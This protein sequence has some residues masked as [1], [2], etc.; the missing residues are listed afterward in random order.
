[1]TT[2]NNK[3]VKSIVAVSLVVLYCLLLAPVL[4]IGRYDYHCADDFGFSAS[5][6][7]A[8]E[9]THSIMDVIHVAG[10]SVV[11]RWHTWQGTF[12]TMFIMAIEPGIFGDTFYHLV[13]WIMIGLMTISVLYTFYVILVKLIGCQKS[14]WISLSMLYLIYA[15][16]CIVDPL[17][18]FFWY[19]G[20]VHYMI[21]HCLALLLVGFLVEVS[22]GKKKILLLIISSV[23]AFLLGGSNY[24]TALGTSIGFGYAIA[25]CFLTKK[26]EKLWIYI[27]PAITFIPAF[28]INVIAPGNSVRQ[29]TFSEHIGPIKAIMLSFY[30]C[31]ERAFS[32]WLDWK[33]VAFIVFITPFLLVIVRATRDRMAY[34]FKYPLLV[35]IFSFCFLSALFTPTSYTAGDAGG[36]RV[37]NIIFLDYIL[38]IILNEA[39]F[40]GW[41]NNRWHIV[42]KVCSV[43][44][45]NKK[46][47]LVCALFL[48]GVL[49]CA[50]LTILKDENSF[51]TS[52]AV[53]SLISGE[54]A[55]YGGETLDRTKMIENCG[56]DLL[57]VPRFVETPY[58]LYMDDIV[59]DSDDWRNQSMSRYYGFER[60][61]A[62]TKD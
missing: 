31:I 44:I 19:N 9:S 23:M 57:E 38:M 42:N 7:L 32:Y 6:H 62:F 40:I 60:V 58:L 55:R 49:F 43:D 25:G 45:K 8:W 27:I 48:F 4:Y 39:Y 13:P 14:I 61:V 20:A 3:D 36:G 26:K 53:A 33:L 34:E 29:A 1:M 21:P 59:P 56:G 17:Q 46:N 54:A 18:G 5:T 30:Y 15:L 12:T 50:G 10:Q 11:D 24:I 37:E 41:L 35:F 52:S 51:T 16:E 47:Q 28:I 22:T 2:I